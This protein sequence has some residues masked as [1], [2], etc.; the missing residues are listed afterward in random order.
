M[1]LSRT[2]EVEFIDPTTLDLGLQR[3]ARRAEFRSGT[4][5]AADSA[6]R[7][8]QWLITSCFPQRR[9]TGQSLPGLP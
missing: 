8:R 1:S 7:L 3:L 4:V 2:S 9:L 5:N 6:C